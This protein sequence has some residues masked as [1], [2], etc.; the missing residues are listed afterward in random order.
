MAQGSDSW[1]GAGMERDGTGMEQGGGAC[2]T[3]PGDP[4]SGGLARV[5]VFAS[6]GDFSRSTGNL[7]HCTGFPRCAGAGPAQRR[8]RELPVTLRWVWTRRCAAAAAAAAAG[9]SSSSQYL[10]QDGAARPFRFLILGQ[11]V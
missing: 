2:S 10:L 8:P 5:G 6:L 4:G 9:D 3:L 11:M 1:G 7:F